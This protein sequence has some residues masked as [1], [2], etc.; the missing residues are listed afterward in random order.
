MAF[1][2]RIALAA[3]GLA[4]AATT[5][6]AQ[7]QTTTPWQ[8]R[9]TVGGDL[10]V[11]LQRW[12]A[13]STTAGTS[14]N[15]KGTTRVRISVRG[16][17]TD[18][19]AIGMRLSTFG[20]VQGTG[21]GSNRATN[22]DYNRFSS[23]KGIGVDLA[24]FDYK[25]DTIMFQA[26]KVPNLFWQA[27]G[28]NLN[29]HPDHN[30][31]GVQTKWNGDMGAMKPFATL[32]YANLWDRVNSDTSTAPSS[33]S[34]SDIAWFGAQAGLNWKMDPMD[35]NF[36]ISS[37]NVNN[38]KQLPTASVGSVGHTTETVSGTTVY[39]YDVKL[40][41]AGLEFAYNMG[42]GPAAVYVD[43]SQN[44]DPSDENKGMVA[45]VKLG[46][47]KK[48]NDWLI[49]YNYRDVRKDSTYGFVN[50]NGFNGVNVDYYGH[51][52]T[53]GYQVWPNSAFLIT[54]DAGRTGISTASS[55][56]VE[57]WYF[58]WVGSF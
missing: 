49:N 44:S 24:Y 53:V 51:E 10:R 28:S 21:I 18:N 55:T 15:W 42:F 5:V 54:L 7:A 25:M 38:M 4:V 8:D 34:G 57:S 48:Q 14:D 26:G 30:W 19:L 58:D 2:D 31:E 47:L 12:L 46:A 16:K 33:S 32:N 45:G 56:N 23:K 17:L 6:S 52:T 37:F 29:F 35:I 11:R 36:A 3:V 39:K 20:V 13:G 27:G 41:G 22:D 1:F 43:Y 40:L 9:V 50:Y